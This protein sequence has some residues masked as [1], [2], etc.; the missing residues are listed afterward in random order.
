MPLYPMGALPSRPDHRDYPA[1]RASKP[2]TLPPRFQHSLL[3]PVRDQGAEGTCVGHALAASVMGHHQL[4]LPSTARPYGRTLSPR[5]A[6]EGGRAQDIWDLMVEV[7][8]RVHAATGIVLHQ[9]TCLV[10]FPEMP[11]LER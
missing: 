10:G 9:E 3:Q 1:P 6:Y 8:R 5:D 7:R 11:E 4:V 2:G